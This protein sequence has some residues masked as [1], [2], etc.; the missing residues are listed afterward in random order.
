[1]LETMDEHKRTWHIDAI[2]IPGEFDWECNARTLIDY[3][4]E[5]A[6]AAQIHQITR[7]ARDY[8][9]SNFVRVQ[10]AFTKM[11]LSTHKC[12]FP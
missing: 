11:W 10:E 12:H 6:S 7:N 9:I 4:G 2:Q 1:M 5:S 3:L 8:N